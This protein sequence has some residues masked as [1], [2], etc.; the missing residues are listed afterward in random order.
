MCAR[1][2]EE[3]NKA[4]TRKAHVEIDNTPLALRGMT[5]HLAAIVSLSL[6]V[7]RCSAEPLS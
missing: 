4:L 7:H 2:E 3:T 1:L 6:G 5:P